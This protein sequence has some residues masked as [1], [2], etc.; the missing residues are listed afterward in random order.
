[1]I[2]EIFSQKNGEK[3]CRFFNLNHK[4]IVITTSIPGAL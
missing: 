1:M 3:N 2:F 4:K